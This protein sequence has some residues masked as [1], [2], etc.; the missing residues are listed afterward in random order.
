MNFTKQNDGEN[1]GTKMPTVALKLNA[2][3]AKEQ[4]HAPIL[5][6]KHRYFKIKKPRI[7]CGN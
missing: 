4:K 2:Y 6:E 5:L 3:Q 1:C 7:F